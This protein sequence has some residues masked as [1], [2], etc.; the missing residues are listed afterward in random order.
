[1]GLSYK[2][3]GGVVVGWAETQP[4]W[5]L[6]LVGAT[7]AWQLIFFVIGLPG[8]ALAPLLVTIREPRERQAQAAAPTRDVV[9]YILQNR[10]TFLL[11]NFG[12]ALNLARRVRHARL[13]SRVLP[14]T[15]S[16]GHQNCRPRV[17][18]HRLVGRDCRPRRRGRIADRVFA[19]GRRAA[20]FIVAAGI[21]ALLVP[22]NVALFLAPSA[23]W[24]TAW[25]VL[26]SV[27]FAAPFGMAPTAIQQMMP[28]TMRGQ[29]SAVYSS[30]A[31]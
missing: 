22:L 27:L 7:H 9:A 11:H 25:L 10:R 17:R 31:R 1:M 14:P 23:G 2:M 3:L 18:G 6:P 12:F 15:L 28:P 4:D 16:L 19:T 21:A 26:Q 24:A 8:V 13:G 20:V 29:A 5:H 30:S